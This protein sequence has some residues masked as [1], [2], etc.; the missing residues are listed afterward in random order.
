VDLA[1]GDPVAGIIEMAARELGADYAPCLDFDSAHLKLEES[2]PA[3]SQL[4]AVL[5]RNA[6]RLLPATR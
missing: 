5:E 1:G 3:P 6:G 2:A 4:R